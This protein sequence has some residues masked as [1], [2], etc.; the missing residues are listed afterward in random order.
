V[1]DLVR[2]EKGKGADGLVMLAVPLDS[3]NS[4]SAT[5][6]TATTTAMTSSVSSSSRKRSLENE[7]SSAHHQQHVSSSSSMTKKMKH[8]NHHNSSSSSSSS[9]GAVQG[10]HNH[11]S[12]M[13]VDNNKNN[14]KNKKHVNATDPYSV[15][16]SG[17]SGSKHGSASSQQHQPDLSPIRPASITVSS[18][19]AV[20]LH[21]GGNSSSSPHRRSHPTLLS[22]LSHEHLES[23][24]HSLQPLQ[25]LTCGAI[26][27]V[28]KG[29]LK[30]LREEETMW[31]FNTPVDPEAWGLSDYFQVIKRP[32]DYS[33]VDKKLDGGGYGNLSEFEEDVRLIYSNARLYNSPGTSVHDIATTTLELFEKEYEKAVASVADM[34]ESADSKDVCVLCLKSKRTYTPPVYICS[35]RNCPHV[36]IRR[37]NNFWSISGGVHFCTQCY[38]HLPER[39]DVEGRTIQKSALIK[40]KNDEVHEEGWVQCDVCK[41]WMHQI[42]GLFNARE[43]V[44]RQLYTC[45]HC[46]VK[47]HRASNGSSKSIISSSSRNKRSQLHAKSLIRTKLSDLLEDAIRQV[48]KN[49]DYGDKDVPGLCIRQVTSRQCTTLVRELM[50][51]TYKPRAYPA[52]FPYRN[53]CLL[54]FQEIDGI[55]TLLFALYV[56]EYGSDCPE[57]NRNRVYISYLDSVHYLRPRGLRTKIYH[58]ILIQYFDYARKRGFEK[59]HIWSCPPA[60]GDDYIFYAKPEDQK[61]P[62]EARLRKWYQQMLSKAQERGIVSSTT[63][64]YD[65]YFAPATPR[66]AALVPY[67]D[68]DYFVGE[69]ENVLSSIAAE[70]KKAASKAEGK[71]GTKGKNSKR[72]SNNSS[73]SVDY[74]DPLMAKIGETVHPMK[75]SFLVATLCHECTVCPDYSGSK[76]LIEGER[77]NGS[78]CG[79]SS[80]GSIAKPSSHNTEVLDEDKEEMDCEILDSRQNFLNLCKG[81]HY[82]FDELRRAKHTSMMILWHLHN[83]NAPK[84]VQACSNCQ[85]EITS[86]MRYHCPTCPEYDL[87]SECYKQQVQASKSKGKCVHGHELEA[88]K[89]EETDGSNSESSSSA[90]ALAARRA[91]Q[92]NVDLHI[93]LLEHAS[94]CH[95]EC[96]SRNCPKMKAYIKEFLSHNVPGMPSSCG[97]CRV[98]KKIRA[99]IGIHAQRCRKSKCGVPECGVFKEK[100]RQIMR[101]QQAMD[102]RRRMEMNRIYRENASA[103][104]N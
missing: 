96:K 57:P 39:V 79:S 59:A 60:R 40:K 15:P 29:V 52:E 72:M 55:D 87:C 64:L 25:S 43:N 45:P 58:E 6:T 51:T 73:S 9:G 5:T 61:I 30:R 1:C 66:D 77:N 37:G 18:N 41:H 13:D 38:S 97:G 27:S 70:Q 22:T 80:K 3:S 11:H 17:S 21:T 23:H 28:C 104:G 33:T 76:T 26:S 4:S 82:Q 74:V 7:S 31:I 53:K 84:F 34:H 90:S 12:G 67:L 69:A 63:N 83:T 44:K 50:H 88:I 10:H 8:N 35:G 2:S 93:R 46:L 92:H 81:N 98:C 36:K 86:G 75:D 78:A 20:T 62:K 47:Q 65:L 71:N 85:M 16:S 68:G 103:S 99:M 95:K 49:S 14:K 102:D 101:Q 54:L 48:I 32:M 42:C 91:Q 56:Y 100:I 24:L 94:N 89:V 19:S